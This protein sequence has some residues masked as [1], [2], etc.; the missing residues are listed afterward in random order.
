MRRRGYN[1]HMFKI[2]LAALTAFAIVWLL[3]PLFVPILKRLKPAQPEREPGG[4]PHKKKQPPSM[5]G[6]LVLLAVTIA[7]LAYG[8][9]GLEFVLPAVL[10]TVG[11]GV[12]GF[13]DDFLKVRRGEGLGAAQKLFIEIIVGI[14]VAVWAY[15]SPLLGPT[16][17]LPVSGGE[18]NIGVWYIPL[19]AFA[20]VSEVNGVSLT[21]G[22][23]G[24]AVNVTMVYALFAGAIFAVLTTRANQEGEILMSTNLY[25]MAVFCAVLAGALIAFLRYNTYPAKI[26]LG[27]TGALALGG[28]VPMMAILSRSL[29]ILPVMGVCFL[30]SAL[31]VSLQ[32]FSG[33]GKEGKRLFKA[34]PLHR[35]YAL[36]GVAEP[37][38]VVVYT[39][40]TA[41]LC[42][43][44]LLPYLA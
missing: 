43:L 7:A 30:A 23:D 2:L 13:L 10:T 8:M 11:L 6:V 16:L 35:H 12:V 27:S 15:R 25:G 29:L 3:G 31:S 22:M 20:F 1:T 14:L 9:E 42:A 34:V 37:R 24:L 17:V 19:A 44:C 21:D 28:A 26:S 5:G 40:V 38:V 4:E 18:W 36:S 39:L 41:A 32:A 33:R